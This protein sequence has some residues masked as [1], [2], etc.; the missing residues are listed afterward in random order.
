MAVIESGSGA[1]LA[2]VGAVAS[3]PLH[4]VNKPLPVGALG[5][6]RWSGV[7]GTMAAAL[8]ASGQFWYLRWADATRFCVIHS[9]KVEFQTLTLFT[10]ATLTDFGFD[11]HKATAMSA[12]AGGTDVF[13][14]SQPTKMRASMGNSLLGALSGSMRLSTT[15]A[16]TALTTLDSHPI[17]Q[18]IGDSQRVNV[19]AGTEEQRVNDPTLLFRPDIASGEWP[20]VLVQNEALVLRNRT[21]WPVAGTGIF[22]VEVAWSEVT[23]EP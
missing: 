20:L 22:R 8:A 19:A 11:L 4:C 18:S 13:S 3:S 15:A 14:A 5:S 2:N 16:L 17:A 12:G 9:V 6:Y 10:G 23:Y 1:A 7:T 21:V